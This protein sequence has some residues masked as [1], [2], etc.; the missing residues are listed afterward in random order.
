MKWLHKANR[1][2]TGRTLEIFCM[3]LFVMVG[4][5]VAATYLSANGQLR[6]PETNFTG[7]TLGWDLRSYVTDAWY[8]IE[9][10]KTPATYGY[11]SVAIAGIIIQ[12]F[13][14]FHFCL[15]DNSTSCSVL[16]YQ[17]EIVGSCLGFLLLLLGVIH[18]SKKRL[19]AFLVF[20][21]FLLGVSMNKALSSGNPDLFL[22]LFFGVIL[23]ILRKKK[24]SPVLLAGFGVFLGLYLNMKAFLLLIV[25]VTIAATG[26]NGLLI[27][28]FLISFAA[29]ALWPQLFGVRA[30][31]LDVFLLGLGTNDAIGH[32]TYLQVNY[33]NNAIIPYVSNVLQA[34]DTHKI[35]LVAHQVLTNILSLF[36]TLAVFVKPWFDQHAVSWVIKKYKP[37]VAM[38]RKRTAPFSFW[39][40]LFTMCY[41]IMLTVTAWSYDYR[42][43]YSIP[44]IFFYLDLSNDSKTKRLLYLSIIF[45]LLKGLWIPKDRIMTAFL[46]IH[47]YYLIRAALSLW[48]NDLSLLGRQKAQRFV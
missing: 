8:T 31:L 27:L 17:L 10:G 30:G 41:F 16:L 37:L 45:L 6:A 48:M 12:L 28:S 13:N 11:G 21:T 25:V 3:A 47:F 36:L 1:C 20:I 43:L 32:W 34:F 40:L 22:S 38:I 7:T 18:D 4:T 33:G 2:I 29:A 19:L 35:P 9:Q 26:L 23:C 24:K 15:P 46:Y 14:L 39:L 42:I 44:L 5:R